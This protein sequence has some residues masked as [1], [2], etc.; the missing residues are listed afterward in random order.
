[1]FANYTATVDN[2]CCCVWRELL[3]EYPDAKLLLTL[4]P[5]GAAGWYD[6]T[7]DTIYL[8]RTSGSSKILEWLTPFGRKFGDMSRKLIWGRVLAGVMDDRQRAI[9]R[10]NATPRR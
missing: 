10:Y 8:P 4:H 5:R 7:I 3:A 6:S 9:A 2:P 1:M